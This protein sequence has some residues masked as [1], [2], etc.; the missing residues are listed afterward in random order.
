MEDLVEIFTNVVVS[1]G[2]N[3]AQ[4]FFESDWTPIE[5]IV[6]YGHDI[7]TSWLVLE[8][9]N[10]LGDPTM[11]EEVKDMSLRLAASALDEGFDED[12]GGLYNGI[13]A[14]GKLDTDK[15]WWPQAEAIVGFVN[16]FTETGDEE[17]LDAAH[18]TWTF[19]RRFILDLE[20]GEWHRRVSR[21]GEVRPGHEKVGPW[22]CPY[23]NAR[24]CLE[25]MSRVDRRA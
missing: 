1:D 5:R 14:R 7:E 12:N 2:A 22:K 18:A 3:H 17:Y 11:Q 23:H 15:E 25:I 4:Q 20:R 13:D 16:A 6:S 19:T 8:A 21:T 9:A 24:A 10:V